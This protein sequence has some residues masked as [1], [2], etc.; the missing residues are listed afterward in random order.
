MFSS[1]AFHTNV[2]RIEEHNQKYDAGVITFTLGL[3]CMK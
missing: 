1:L 2:Q 3:N